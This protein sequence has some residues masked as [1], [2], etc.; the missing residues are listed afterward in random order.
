MGRYSHGNKS[1]D[2]PGDDGHVFASSTIRRSTRLTCTSCNKQLPM[3]TQVVFELD[4]KER[5][6]AVYCNNDTCPP[7]DYEMNEE[8]HPFDLEE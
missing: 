2:L 3:K 1:S 7:F 6:V 4:D 8:R 5:F